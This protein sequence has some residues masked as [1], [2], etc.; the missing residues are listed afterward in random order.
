MTTVTVDRRAAKIEYL[1]ALEEKAKRKSERSLSAFI[2]QAWPIVEP[3][4]EFVDG[5]HLGAIVEHLEAVSAGQIRN[6]VITM[7]PRHMKS[8]AVSVFWPTWEWLTHPSRRWLFASYAQSLSIRDNLKA[9]RLIESPWFTARWRAVFALT[10]DQNVKA[11]FENDQTGYRLATSVGGAATG[12]GGDRI[13]CDDPHNVQDA[14][15]D[16]IRTSTLTW[17]DEVMSSR[18]N[19]PK[20]GAKV[21]VQ[22]RCH[23][24]DLAGHVLEQGTYDHLC[25]PAE[26]EGRK[27]YTSI[28]W[29]DPRVDEGELLW[30][31]R[32]GRKEIEAL[33]VSLVSQYAIAGQLQQRPAPRAG[34]MFQR[35]WFVVVDA[36]PVG[37]IRCRFWDVAGTDGAGDWTVGTLIGRSNEGLYYVLDVC[38]YRKSAGAVDAM[39]VKTATED[40]VSVRIREEQEPGSAGKAVIASRVKS[41][42]GY[43][44]KGEPA[45]GQKSTRWR[46]FAAQAEAGNVRI[47]RGEWNRVWLDELALVPAGKHDDQ[48]D[49][50]AGA[51]NELSLKLG[52]IMP[53]GLMDVG[54]G[55]RATFG[56]QTVL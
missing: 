52:A 11:R 54:R 4:T 36:V 37:L 50:A 16:T 56:L 6:L 28:G 3:T 51:F 12:E 53:E 33:K 32:Y 30:P 19:D 40:G 42:A 10:S 7:P 21:I 18:L 31:A 48:A 39:I 14:E 20:T 55:Q 5:W 49:S 24:Q 8:L 15:S 47:V 38:R 2:R 29:S 1:Q 9:R 44:Y 25:L 17:W 43:D 35:E 34:G 41:L 23:E 26:Y 45:T 22:Q 13:V 46:P 27:T